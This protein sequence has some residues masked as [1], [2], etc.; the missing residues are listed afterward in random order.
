[1]GE[2][3]RPVVLLTVAVGMIVVGGVGAAL[4]GRPGTADPAGAAAGPPPPEA[5]A[6]ARRLTACDEQPRLPGLCATVETVV[7]E[8]L[9]PVDPAVLIRAA[10][11]AVAVAVQ[12]GADER[13]VERRAIAAVLTAL[14]DPHARYRRPG[15]E[16]VLPGRT[17][18]DERPGEP[19]E[20][21]GPVGGRETPPVVAR[22]LDARTGYLRPWTLAGD[23]PDLF[24]ERL[25]E[26]LAHGV[27]GIV[28]DLRGNRG[29]LVRVAR[30]I[31]DELLPAG[32]AFTV[33]R[34]ESRR[35]AATRPGGTGLDV[36]LVVLVD[37]ETASAAE[38]LATALRAGGRATVVGRRTA[39]KATVQ[40]SHRLETGAV[41]RL[42]VGRWA[43]RDGDSLDG[44]GL[45][46]DVTVGPSGD[47][48]VTDHDPA[49]SRA[50]AL[51]DAER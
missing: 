12:G 36:A 41:L 34:R 27:D 11:V 43:T 8:H 20:V 49:V 42:T 18:G 21:G 51:L 35:S 5:A 9:E 47:A 17:P 1:M 23:A 3:R 48:A 24:R 46:P 30:E 39:G 7:A 13:E 50:W 22:L 15:E 4:L 45:V 25:G 29:G 37:E 38:M 2:L 33:E 6:L 19:S 28:L 40:A 14:D 44:V 32:V 10:E 16:A 31:A 26:Q